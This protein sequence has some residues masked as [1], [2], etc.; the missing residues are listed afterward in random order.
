MPPR[1]NLVGQRFGR[2]TV[3][4]FTGFSKWKNSL[5]LCVCDCG[6][7]VIVID[8][9]LKTGG[10]KSCGCLRID[11]IVAIGTIHG[12][13][14]K[15]KQSPEYLSWCAMKSRCLYINHTHYADYGGRGITIYE[16]W[17][18]FVNFLADMGPRPPGTTLE[19]RNNDGNYEPSNCY[20]ATR[21]EQANNRRPRRS[22]VV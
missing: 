13:N 14:S 22:K 3:K 8:H 1:I 4:E 12:H 21:K 16:P 17:L 5:W 10:T 11:T 19:R 20:W 18:E 7:E 15:G 2:L 6:N 9:N